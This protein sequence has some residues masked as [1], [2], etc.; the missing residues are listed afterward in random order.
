MSLLLLLAAGVLLPFPANAGGLDS[1]LVTIDSTETRQRVLREERRA[2][3]ARIGR[4]A[5]EVDSLKQTTPRSAATG[6]LR[7]TLAEAVIWVDRDESLGRD[8]N[9][10]AD[11]L[12]RLR[13]EARQAVER[14]LTR[15]AD[16]LSADPPGSGALRQLERLRTIG[17]HLQSNAMESS[18]LSVQERVKIYNS[19]GPDEIRQKADLVWDMADHVGR[20]A[21]TARHRLKELALEKRLRRSL[22]RF[23]GDVALFDEALPTTRAITTGRKASGQGEG[24]LVGP[25]GDGTL[26]RTEGIAPPPVTEEG[27]TGSEI[28]R[29][30]AT[31]RAHPGEA[32]GLEAE[33]LLAETRMRALALREEQLRTQAEAFRGILRDMLEA[34]P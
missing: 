10:V 33:I 25:E 17:R 7:A 6:R 21:E 30:P 9:L 2:V 14:D 8:L 24:L 27:T 18:E 31:R 16:A 22:S 23:A 4:I 12:K 15:M 11:R 29:G 28:L 20:E 3:R 32:G 1:L 26:D 19:D 34:A 13:A 5:R